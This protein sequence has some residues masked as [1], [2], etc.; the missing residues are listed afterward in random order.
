MVSADE[1]CDEEIE[2]QIGAAVV[3]VM[4]KEVLETELRANEQDKVENI[5]CNMAYRANAQL[6]MRDLDYNMQRKRKNKIYT[7]IYMRKDVLKKSM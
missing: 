3:E 1:K 2:Q 7:G 5:Q 4:R 6:W